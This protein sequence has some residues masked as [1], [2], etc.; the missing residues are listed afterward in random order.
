MSGAAGA[1]HATA[2][3]VAPAA[4][5]NLIAPAPTPGRRVPSIAEPPGGGCVL[6]KLTPWRGE[7]SVRDLRAGERSMAPPRLR[8][9]R[10]SP[11][12]CIG[13]RQRR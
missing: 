6:P 12:V 2:S 8:D 3:G 9:A 4:G 1:T 10:D 7:K 11:A 13:A 5:I